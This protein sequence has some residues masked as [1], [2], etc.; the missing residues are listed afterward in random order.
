MVAESAASCLTTT[1]TTTVTSLLPARTHTHVLLRSPSSRF[2]GIADVTNRPTNAASPYSD[3]TAVTAL[4]TVHTPHTSSE[5]TAETIFS[6]YSDH[7]RAIAGTALD[8]RSESLR[9]SGSNHCPILDKVY[10][11][12]T[13]RQILLS[14][15][16]AAGRVL[17]WA[18]TWVFYTQPQCSFGRVHGYFTPNF[19]APLGVYMD[20]LHPTSPHAPSS[21][22]PT[23]VDSANTQLPSSLSRYSF[24]HDRPPS[25]VRSKPISP[26][27]LSSSSV[28]APIMTQSPYNN[29]LYSPSL[30]RYP[31][32]DSN[33]T[34]SLAMRSG[35]VTSMAA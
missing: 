20:I 30:W 5:A 24:K 15:A 28:D 10:Q 27:G 22:G 18:C 26:S 29:A 19:G 16:K 9:G 21:H 3:P 12:H 34:C 23:Q 4:G 2:H 8:K 31:C 6:L 1:T 14:L 17:L 7:R 32:A 35:S 13:H 11:V 25:S 33:A